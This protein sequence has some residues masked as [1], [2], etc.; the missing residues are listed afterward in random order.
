MTV[1][2]CVKVNVEKAPVT[3]ET[4][5][6]AS[7]ITYGDKLS[8]SVL[9][10]GVAMSGEDEIEG[11][12]E[13][14]DGT[15]A[16]E[17]S[18]S[19]TTGYDVVFTPED[20]VNY[21]NAECEVTLEV[22]EPEAA[23]PDSAEPDSVE[24]GAVG[25]GAAEEAADNGKSSAPEAGDTAQNTGAAGTTDTTDMSGANGSTDMSGTTGSTDMSVASKGPFDNTGVSATS[26][27][28]MGIS[29]L[30]I[31]TKSDGTAVITA[32]SSNQKKVTV[33]STVEVDGVSYTVTA[34]SKGAFKNC[35]KAKTITLPDTVNTI[36]KGSFTG[37]KKLKT[38]N[39]G[40]K[41][42][43]TVKK[44]AFSGLDTSGIT[45]N[46]SEKMSKKQLKKFKSA[47]TKAGFEG[48]VKNG[49]SSIDTA[50]VFG[51]GNKNIIIIIAAALIA[52]A[53]GTL[54]SRKVK[55]EI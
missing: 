47:L 6:E 9:T 24:P 48:K 4:A 33:D 30:T 31:N 3:V 15:A 7:A 53:A 43:I 55:K 1:P 36:A 41:K 28:S 2:E 14:A 37:A 40:V 54:A 16:P 22:N 46:A 8:E 26:S 39:I 19:N 32:I 44:G 52:I 13:W 42:S 17:V 10:G 12:F 5:P 20:D 29:S 34:I 27:G 18:D 45:I 38:L 25:T 50:S 35:A 23:E 11:K 49:Y 51:D 21:K